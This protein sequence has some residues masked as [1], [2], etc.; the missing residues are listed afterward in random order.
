VTMLD[1]IPDGAA[2]S[3]HPLWRE[4]IAQI[5]SANLPWGDFDGKTILIAGAN[6]FLPAAMVETLL[7]LAL[8]SAPRL[9]V[10]ALARSRENALRRFAAHLGHPALSIKIA[11]VSQPVEID[12][13][14]DMIVHA[15]SQASPRF[16]GVDPVGT[17]LPNV[18]GA[19]H[20]L[21]LARRKGASRFLYFSSSEVYGSLDSRRGP[22]VETDFGALDPVALRACYA[23]SKRMGETLCISYGAQYGIDCVIARP[24]HTYGPGMRLDDGRV[25]ADFVRDVVAGRNIVLNSDGAAERAFCYLA[26][27]T[28]A[29]FTLLL[30]GEKSCAYNVGNSRAVISIR[31]LAALLTEFD[32]E[33]RLSAT[34][35][36]PRD[37]YIVSRV[38]RSAPDTARLEKLGWRPQTS[39]E[40]GF[41]RTID[42]YRDIF[43]SKTLGA[44]A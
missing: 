39:V 1:A 22:I 19:H 29:F 6:G 23:E 28:Q 24:F 34:F 17:A 7:A 16:Y 31:D 2:L 30:K 21:E 41:R 13:P 5:L 14:V 15:A 35:A 42:I 11:D 27:A 10:V 25:F 43:A 38:A 44:S 18:V 32:P 40:A 4:D 20:L 3:R 37:G 26:D 36:A 9:K 33:R 8:R 12:G